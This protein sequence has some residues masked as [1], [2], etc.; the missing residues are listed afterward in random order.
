[1]IT[2]SPWLKRAVFLA[3]TLAATLALLPLASISIG[4]ALADSH[5]RCRP[6]CSQLR[7]ASYLL[8]PKFL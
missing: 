5:S 8:N 4:A 6:T 7:Q 3:T 2:F 1:M